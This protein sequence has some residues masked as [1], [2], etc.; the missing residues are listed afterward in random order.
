[1][2]EM[3]G[4]APT[5]TKAPYGSVVEV[6]LA[7]LRLGCTSFG[8]P[9]AHLAYFRQEFVQKRR[10]L[11][12]DQYAQLL[13]LCQF[14]PGPASSQL[15][16]SLGLLRAGWWGGAAAFVGFT[17]PSALLLILFA[18][19][20][21][22]I[23]AG[24]GESIVHGLKVVAFVV[25]ADALM[26][27]SKKLCFDATR[28]YIA[29]LSAA[30]VLW[31]AHPFVQLIAI[32]VGALVGVKYCRNTPVCGQGSL[33]VPYGKTASKWFFLLFVAL[34]LGL[35][36]LSLSVGGLFSI[37]EAFY[38]SGALVFGGGHVVLP[39]LEE[40]LV[41]P[42]WVSDE[43]FLAGYGAAQA[44]PGPMFSFAA[45]LGALMGDATVSIPTAVLALLSIFL[46]GFLLV[47]AVLPIWMQLAGNHRIVNALAGVNA[48]VVGI[49][50]AALYDPIF[51]SGILS[52][53]DL[54]IGLVALGLL[55]IAKL[56][57]LFIVCWCVTLSVIV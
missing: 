31:I 2:R 17:A 43:Q 24:M 50:G 35:P 3:N 14:L 27:M 29:I 40:T 30:V 47:L 12:D 19:M 49:L 32:A 56:S 21:P 1:M 55:Q 11:S 36:V 41:V 44:I 8:G 57:P 4:S 48:A 5:Q 33:T 51:T 34:L 15:G 18:M 39:L 37:S 25:V 42:G 20:L 10:W 38:R 45:Y 46:P 9:I 26:G 28:K 23:P 13:A 7:F 22:A 53:K 54:A 16:F 52:G 6:W